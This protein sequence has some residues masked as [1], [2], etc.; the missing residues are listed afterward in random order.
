VDIDCSIRWFVEVPVLLSCQIILTDISSGH[1]G[2]DTVSH[3][4]YHLPRIIE[5]FL[6]KEVNPH[7]GRPRDVGSVADLLRRAIS[8]FDQAIAGDILALFPGGLDRLSALPDEEIMNVLNDGGPNFK[9][10]RLCL[11]GTTALVALTDPAH[12]HMWCAN[13][14][15]CQA[16]TPCRGSTAVVP[17]ISE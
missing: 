11:Y 14:G 13:L 10:A 17:Y 4:A 7:T 3:T 2:E 8:S 12:T 5:D 1:L 16:G 9:K 6:Q 15:D